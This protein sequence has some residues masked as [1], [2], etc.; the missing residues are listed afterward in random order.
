MR[1]LAHPAIFS[2]SRSSGGGGRGVGS[3]EAM[4]TEWGAVPVGPRNFH[5]LLSAG[6]SVLLFPGGAREAA[7][8]K[9]EAYK[10]FWP[11]R[12]EFV[13]FAA[14]FGATIVPFAA[15]GCEDSL[16]LVLDASEL[17]A[18]PLIGPALTAR[19]RG[20]TPP[21]RRGVSANASLETDFLLP[22]AVPSGPP[23]RM[24]FKFGAP[25][26][27]DP[28]LASDRAAANAIYR[29]VKAEVE[30]GIAWLRAERARDPYRGGAVR[31]PYEAVAG[32]RQAP[33]F[34]L[35]D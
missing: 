17:A 3:F 21:A 33:T 7:K 11:D 14:R 10:L 31:L 26:K 28:S 18:L 22:L 9:G 25:I 24:Y 20:S 34:S 35:D 23:D 4:L 6:E 27:L 12:E 5:R 16:R 2:S 13:R 1:G 8:L 30:A 19:A 15:V 32:G 29:D